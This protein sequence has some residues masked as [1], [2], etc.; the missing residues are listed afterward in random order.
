[1][2][3]AGKV[4]MSLLEH[5]RTLLIAGDGSPIR[6][7]LNRKKSKVQLAHSTENSRSGYQ[8]WLPPG[9]H[10]HWEALLVFS[11]FWMGEGYD[12]L[13]VGIFAARLSPRMA[14]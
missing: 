4:R 14:K 3:V 12:S 7:G 8:A 10:C 13:C 11:P 2:G 1:M 6:V 5:V 9:T